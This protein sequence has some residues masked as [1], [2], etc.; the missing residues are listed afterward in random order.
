MNYSIGGNVY[1]TVGA[2]IVFIK[3]FP[4]II[5]EYHIAKFRNKYTVIHIY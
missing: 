2:I 3:R 4:L 5:I 1:I